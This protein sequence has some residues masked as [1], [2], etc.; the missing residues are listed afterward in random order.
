MSEKIL[1]ALMQLFAIIARVDEVVDLEEVE[2]ITSSRGRKVV[3]NFLGQELNASLVEEYLKI[4][5]EYLNTHHGI[6]RRKNGVKKRTSVN[7][8]KILRICSE[9]N[10]ELT[11]KQKIIVLVRI[12]EFIQ[13]NDNVE[14]Q[15]IE[16][17]NT[18]G[19]SFNVSKEEY[20]LLFDFIDLNSNN[21]QDHPNILYITPESNSDLNKAKQVERKDVEGIIAF[22]KVDSVNLYFLKYVG[23][24]Q[25]FLNG[26]IISRSRQQVFNP[27]SSIRTEKSNPIYYSDI[28]TRFLDDGN[29]EHLLFECEHVEYRFPNNKIGLHD[30]NFSEN[31]G[32]LVGIMG[33]SGAG[34][35]TLLNV[36]N[37]NLSPYSGSVKINGIDIH[38]E[39]SE[40][41]GI[42]GFISQDDLLIE[43]LT[44]FENLYFNAQLCF[45]TLNKQQITKKVI[46][47]L[48]SIGLYEVQSLKVGSP[49]EKTISG[50]QRKRLNIALELIREPSVLF[51]DEPTSGLSSRDSEN[52]M[53][54]LKELALKGKLIFVVIHQPSS[55]I[56]KMFDRLMI[57]DQGGYPIFYGDSVDSIVYFKTEIEH[58]N[59]DEREC[60]TCGNV[61][62]EQIFNI[63]EAKVVDEFG[64]LTAK[65]K[66]TPEEWNSR[67]IQARIEHETDRVIGKPNVFNK[68]PNKL[69]QFSV[70]FK[71][72]I[73]SKLTNQQYVLLNTIEAPVLALILGFFVKY[74]GSTNSN[75]TYTFEN[76]EN[77]PQF[78]FIAVVVAL[79]LGLT[80]AAEEIIKDQKILKRESFLNLSRASYIFSKISIMFIISAFQ[81][82]MFV[83]IGNY[84]LEIKGMWLEYWL[85]LFST[86]CFANILGLNISSTF[87]SAKVIYILIP[88]MIIPQLLFSGVIVQFD[89]LHPTISKE[90][91][92]PWIGNIMASRWAY[93]GLAVVQYK[94][95]KYE[96]PF[97]TIDQKKSEASW[98]RD[99]WLPE[100]RNQQSV[101]INNYHEKPNSDKVEKAKKVLINEIQK[102]EKL[103]DPSLDFTC[104]GCVDALKNDEWNEEISKNMTDYFKIL[105]N[106]YMSEVN[107][108]MEGRT[109]RINQIG[110]EKYQHLRT[111]YFN[112][113]LSDLATNRNNLD[114]VIYVNNQ[115]IQKADP[116]YKVPRGDSFFETHFYAPGKNLFGIYIPT[117][118]ANILVIWMMSVL[119][120]ITLYF[121]LFRKLFAGAS[122]IFQK[123]KRF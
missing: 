105:K 75:S 85:I 26:Q 50:G 49:L 91:S 109:K 87:N 95:N 32:A 63:I 71:R 116:I 56:F 16:F 62:P 23:D 17:V 1:R 40:I 117:F 67:Y 19:E 22:I 93:E 51:V 88:I 82:A 2:V 53:D 14:S 70:Y 101:L 59:S 10:Q 81:T 97:Y 43:E 83:L 58:A 72:D 60:P 7:S 55:D 103:Y 46:A 44:V 15:E 79:F 9:I 57:L 106:I 107:E 114:K 66:I 92:V 123:I 48:K 77:L 37:G 25:I 4:F 102:E 21:I 20:D 84:I 122:V 78:L 12:I 41:E 61:N 115:I 69:K 39:K 74:F 28:I 96:A 54:L 80:V 119:L 121:D 27:G 6:K 99:Y 120:I 68:I 108:A 31:N 34:K 98:K 76:S 64:N 38:K 33:G 13:S 47:L 113:S 8:V 29:Q 35:S 104:S 24:S 30:V 118:Y 3:K 11:Q 100:L 42:I 90:N 65:R 18:V 73:L 36:L 86:S 111:N 94:K 89:K 5:D 110:V 45:S 52:I 112:E